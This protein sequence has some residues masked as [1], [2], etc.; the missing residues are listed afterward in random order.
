MG[1]NGRSEE[2]RFDNLPNDGLFLGVTNATESLT[3]PSDPVN[4]M[5]EPILAN[6]DIYDDREESFSKHGEK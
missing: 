5:I 6:D 1:N 3:K 2:I 4:H